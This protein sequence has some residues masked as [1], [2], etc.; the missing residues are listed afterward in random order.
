MNYEVTF[1]AR[2]VQ[3]RN[4]QNRTSKYPWDKMVA[5]TV[6]KNEDGTEETM[7]AQFFVPGK[8]TKKLAGL[9]NVTGKR[10]NA[11][12]SCRSAQLEDGTK[13]VLIQRVE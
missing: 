6:T 12:F 2:A 8:T 7:Y 5:P 11:K 9:C 1:G 10:M 4:V 3:T 13:G